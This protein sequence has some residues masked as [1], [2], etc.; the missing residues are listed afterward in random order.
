MY[1]F[2]EYPKHNIDVKINLYKDNS[3]FVFLLELIKV[4]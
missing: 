2:I 1:I 4:F 3:K